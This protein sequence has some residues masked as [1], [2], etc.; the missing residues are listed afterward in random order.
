M[1]FRFL[2]IIPSR[3]D[4]THFPGKPLVDLGG[5][6]MIQHAYE[7]A[8]EALEEV[9][10]A[11]DDSRIEK[12]V[13]SFGGNVVMTSSKHK[14]GT[15]RCYEAYTKIGRR[16][17]VVVNLRDDN[18]FIQPSQIELLKS[19]FTNYSIQIVTLATPF[20]AEDNFAMA[21]S[22][23]NYPKVVINKLHEAM[24]FSRSVIPYMRGKSHTEWSA[25]H[26]YYKHIRMY[27]YRSD[28]LKELA[29][30]PQSPLEIAEGLE[31]LRWLEYGYKIKVAVSNQEII[32]IDTPNDLDTL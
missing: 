18:P 19:C 12:A 8:K 20:K 7:R 27:A 30:L 11:T 5:K 4:S 28:V 26:T 13:R 25:I 17:N 31:Q 22:N 6:P 16:Y 32:G 9:F 29:H 24:Y 1:L 15:E 23:K 10:V 14:S 21:L 3:Y 2:G